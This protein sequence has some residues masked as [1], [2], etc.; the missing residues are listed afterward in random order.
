MS[1]PRVWLEISNLL[2]RLHNSVGISQHCRKH[3]PKIVPFTLWSFFY[4]QRAL[5]ILYCIIVW[6]KI[7]FTVILFLY[8][9]FTWM[10]W[11]NGNFVDNTFKIV[12]TG[13]LRSIRDWPLQ[14]ITSGD[15]LWEIWSFHGKWPYHQQ[16]FLQSTSRYTRCYRLHTPEA[17]SIS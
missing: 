10:H 4:R 3:F 9:Q 12:T 2:K 1:T 17:V 5:R 8:V 16:W 7:F 15:V 13:S 11:V 14:S 6:W